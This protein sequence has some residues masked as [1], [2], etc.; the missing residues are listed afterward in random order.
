MPRRR[1]DARQQLF[2]WVWSAGP[3]DDQV[4]DQ[5]EDLD[6]DPPPPP[7]SPPPAPLRTRVKGGPR[8]LWGDLAV[9][10]RPTPRHL[11]G[12]DARVD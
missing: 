1:D 2:D 7:R 9:Y 10:A 3:D 5:V 8:M 11:R 4:D 12:P 6:D